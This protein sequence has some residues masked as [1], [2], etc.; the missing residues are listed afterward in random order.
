VSETNAGRCSAE[1]LRHDNNSPCVTEPEQ[2][3]RPAVGITCRFLQIS[4]RSLLSVVYRA[5]MQST[6]YVSEIR[7]Y[8]NHRNQ[9]VRLHRQSAP[10]VQSLFNAKRRQI[11][12]LMRRSHLLL[13]PKQI[14]RRR[15]RELERSA[16]PGD[17][18]LAPKGQT[19][20]H[21]FPRAPTGAAAFRASKLAISDNRPHLFG[22]RRTN[23]F[24][25]RLSRLTQERKLIRPQIRII[26]IHVRIARFSRRRDS[27]RR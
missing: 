20:G 4:E 9:S 23:R 15:G 5:Q 16:H 26:T 27:L 12:E 18:P 1:W 10:R 25:I 24:E 17:K 13:Y 22:S 8:R 21:T 19:R 2:T 6:I 7:Y 3:Y 11:L 14:D